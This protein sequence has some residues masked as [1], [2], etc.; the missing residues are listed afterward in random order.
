[1]LVLNAWM[2]HPVGAKFV[3]GKAVVTS[4]QTILLNPTAIDKITHALS[5]AVVT[6]CMFVFS[7]AAWYSLKQSHR[8]IAVR[9]LKLAAAVG[10]VASICVLS[11]G[12]GS[13]Y[14]VAEF[15]P[16][17]FAAFEGIWTTPDVPAGITLIAIPDVARQQNSY[18]LKVP[19]LLSF[20]MARDGG[21]A[22]EGMRNIVD[23]AIAQQDIDDVNATARTQLPNVSLL[24]FSFRAMVLSGILTTLVF[25]VGLFRSDAITSGRHPI[26]IRMC[27]LAFPLPW[28]GTLAGWIVAEAGRQPWL[29]Y[30]VLSTRSAAAMSV[31]DISILAFTFIVCSYLL[32]AMLY[33]LACLAYIRIGP[34]VDKALPWPYIIDWRHIRRKFYASVR[35]LQTRKSRSSSLILPR[36][37][38]RD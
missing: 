31:P 15:Q 37:V 17:K 4:L 18:E 28:I 24:F 2:Q 30:G 32:L 7:I 16:L 36:H 25:G 6:G 27:V 35:R 23:K 1:M 33:L 3:N 5:A 29:V 9:S 21:Y 11:S 26:L 38:E 12:H 14:N 19:Y 34:T 8:E 13:A 20:L 22:P 10:A